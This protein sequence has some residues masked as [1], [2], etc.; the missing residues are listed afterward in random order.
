[1]K[2]QI[3]QIVIDAVCENHYW[4]KP[5]VAYSSA[6]NKNFRRLKKSVSMTHAMPEDLLADAESVIS[7]FIPFKKEYA[8]SNN[9]P[10]AASMLWTKMY[11]ETNE[12]INNISVKIEEFLKS[13]NNY[14]F[15]F[16]ATHNFDEEKLISDWSH[17]HV[18][19][20][21][22]L[23]KFGINNMLI[24]E[25]GCCGRFGS[26]ITTAKFETDDKQDLPELC[27][28]KHSGTCGICADKCEN[29]ALQR[30]SFNRFLCYESCLKNA[31]LFGGE[32]KADV[33]GKCL[34]SLSCSYGSPVK[35]QF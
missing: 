5:L 15:L 18:A 31:E 32:K 20:I 22:R 26:L 13:E 19:E 30:E 1:M 25:A 14:C 6:L 27:L 11:I 35:N 17:R 29:G 4:N 10:G 3:E 9:Q 34:V 7:F 33:C 12:L 16:P 28:Y 23:G 2:E 24:T 21:C 8:E